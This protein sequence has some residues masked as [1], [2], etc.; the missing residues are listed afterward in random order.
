MYIDQPLFSEVEI[1]LRQKGF[2]FHRFEPLANRVIQQLHLEDDIYHEFVQ[3]LWADAVFRNGFYLLYQFGNEQIN[4]I[5]LHH[6]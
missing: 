6:A 5:S 3:I 2:M 4:E 1:F